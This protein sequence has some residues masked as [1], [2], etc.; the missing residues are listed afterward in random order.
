MVNKEEKKKRET[1]KQGVME[2]KRK[3]EEG[4]DNEKVFVD[5]AIKSLLYSS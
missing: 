2:K 5:K 1:E 4:K 3:K